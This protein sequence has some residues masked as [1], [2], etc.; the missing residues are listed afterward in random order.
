[1]A[2]QVL[3]AGAQWI[4][5]SDGHFSLPRAAFSRVLQRILHH[6]GLLPPISDPFVSTFR[7]GFYLFNVVWDERPNSESR[8]QVR[9]SCPDLILNVDLVVMLKRH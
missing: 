4:C 7:V 6:S 8:R 9:I 5:P 2:C 1:M 3:L